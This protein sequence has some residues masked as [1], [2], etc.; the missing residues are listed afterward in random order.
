MERR[1][2]IDPKEIPEKGVIVGPVHGP[3]LKMMGDQEASQLI[4]TIGDP[5]RGIPPVPAGIEDVGSSQDQS[6]PGIE[7]VI[8]PFDKLDPLFEIEMLDDFKEK[9]TV[10]GFPDLLKAVEVVEPFPVDVHA[11]V[12]ESRKDPLQPISK[13]SVRRADVQDL[14]A[15]PDGSH[16]Q[17]K[18]LA[19][20][21]QI[22]DI[23]ILFV[24]LIPM[25]K[26]STPGDPFTH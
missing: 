10:K 13:V 17:G 26:E 1:H 11:L 25:L 15:I 18:P 24:N 5:M 16:H 14:F 21:L 4:V 12:K 20:D 3:D 2:P 9:N 23:G 6:A 8:N 22:P 7:E 19:E